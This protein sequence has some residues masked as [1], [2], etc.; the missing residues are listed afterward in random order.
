MCLSNHCDAHFKYHIIHQL[1]LNKVE[2]KKERRKKEGR[3]GEGRGGRKKEKE[4]KKKKAFFLCFQK[5]FKI[6]LSLH[7]TIVSPSLKCLNV[8]FAS[9]IKQGMTKKLRNRR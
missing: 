2:R 5:A 9:V 4:K 1:C 3:E 6:I 8:C 7:P